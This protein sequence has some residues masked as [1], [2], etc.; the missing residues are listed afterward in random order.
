[1]RDSCLSPSGCYCE[2]FAAVQLLAG[3]CKDVL[4]SARAFLLLNTKHEGPSD[5]LTQAKQSVLLSL[6]GP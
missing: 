1:V 5:D 3:T 4:W 6:I 2:G